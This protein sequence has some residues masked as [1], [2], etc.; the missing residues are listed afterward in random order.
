VATLITPVASST[1]AAT[2]TT[3]PAPRVFEEHFDEDAASYWSFL[4]AGNDQGAT[5]PGTRD[6]FLVF[7]LTA[8]NEWGYMLYRPYDYKDVTVEAKVQNRTGGDGAAGVV[9]RYDQKKGWYELNVYADQTYQLLF[10]Q[11]LTEGVA[12]YTPL[13]RG[14]AAIIQG[15]SNTVSLQ[16]RG[17]LLTPVV[18]GLQLRQWRETKFALLR[19]KI[20]LAVSSFN[21]APFTAAFDSVK[22]TEP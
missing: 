1:P 7:D 19:G 11:W 17:T 20:G 18:N 12:S 14:Q 16:C 9:C 15:D 22:V 5:T 8:S 4:R 10:G 21:D 13:A 2:P 6:G 3:R